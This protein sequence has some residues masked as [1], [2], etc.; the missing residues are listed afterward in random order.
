MRKYTIPVIA[1]KQMS[2]QKAKLA[3]AKRRREAQKRR[4]EAMQLALLTGMLRRSVRQAPRRNAK[5]K[6]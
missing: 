2:L 1:T 6:R 3:A 4:E 5:G